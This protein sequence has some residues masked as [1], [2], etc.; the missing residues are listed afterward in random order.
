MRK[1][2]AVKKHVRALAASLIAL[3][4]F[5]IIAFVSPFYRTS[6]YWAAYA[7]GMAAILMMIVVCFY[8][9]SS[10]RE[11][12]S[13][14]YGWSLI[15]IASIYLVVQLLLSLLFMT[16]SYVF[17]FQGW[18]VVVSG[19]VCLCVALLG[20]IATDSAKE[21]IE[22][23]DQKVQEKVFY[24]K[25]MEAD[26]N[27]MAESCSDAALRK[28][29]RGLAEAIKYSDPMSSP[30]LAAVETKLETIC[31]E[32]GE[33]VVESKIDK[34]RALCKEANQVLIERNQKC[35]LLK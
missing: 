18:I 17:Q 31:T 1:V 11:L 21:A 13:R 33:L 26:L 32:I 29:I 30:Q 23:I 28:D 8:A 24:I 22:E 20:M 5:N 15:R 3:A 34:A 10:D 19:S 35:K 16:F 12:K 14:F 9:N 25:F 4:L 27:S 6:A 7:F 2:I